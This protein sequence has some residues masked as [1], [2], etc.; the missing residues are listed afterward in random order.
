MGRLRLFIIDLLKRK[1][2]ICWRC[3]LLLHCFMN[4]GVL[5]E[6][7]DVFKFLWVE[8]FPLFRSGKKEAQLL[9]THHPFTAPVPDD[10]PLLV[11]SPLNTRGLH[12]DLVVNGVELGGGS[13]RI[14]SAKM[15][16]Y[17]FEHILQVRN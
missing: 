3:P 13:I 9:S 2:I 8:N 12:Y 7:K 15:Q 5:A 1:G 17:I 6:S 11:T 14:H 16:E 4:L 10:I